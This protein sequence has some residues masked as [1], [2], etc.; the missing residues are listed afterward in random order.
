[1]PKPPKSTADPTTAPNRLTPEEIDAL[2]E[3]ARR[4]G[5]E[6]RAKRTER[7]KPVGPQE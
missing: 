1:M 7:K 3:H 5:A 4:M 6:I 2:R